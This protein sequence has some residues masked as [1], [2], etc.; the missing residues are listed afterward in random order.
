MDFEKQLE[1]FLVKTNL[2]TDQ[3]KYKLDQKSKVLADNKIKE[4]VKSH[5]YL[6]GRCFVRSYKSDLFPKMNRYYKVLT[7]QA[8][9]E[10]R[11]E[12]LVFDERPT[13][14]FDYKT[15]FNG[16]SPGDY[17]LGH[18]DFDSFFTDSVMIDE[19]LKMKE[20]TIEEYNEAANKYLKELLDLKFVAEHYRFGEVWPTDKDW[21]KESE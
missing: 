3:L 9:N 6:E 11:V 1:E 17:F 2:T 15:Q 18:F 4:S 21:S 14:W 13:Y 20:I 8:D 5:K 7:A 16:S 12:C 10:F 19:L